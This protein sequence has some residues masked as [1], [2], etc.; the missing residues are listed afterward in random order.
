MNYKRLI[1]KRKY[2]ALGILLALSVFSIESTYKI[3]KWIILKSIKFTKWLVRYIQFVKSGYSYS[4]ICQLINNMS[5][6][7]F[8]VF[9]TEVFKTQD[10]TKVVLTQETS[11]GGKDIILYGNNGITYV[12]TKRWKKE[13]EV[14]RERL[15]KLVGAAI[16]DKID[17]MIFITTSGYNKNAYEYA[18]KINNLILWDMNDIM[19]QIV[20]VDQKKLIKILAKSIN[21]D[22][23]IVTLNPIQS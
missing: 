20:K 2:S 4:E 23:K 22:N 3:A 1:Y 16:G 9:M 13:L 11:D 18:S 7:E 21:S 17:N 10:Y 6:R 12:E 5:G 14:G 15:Q 8:E 19:K